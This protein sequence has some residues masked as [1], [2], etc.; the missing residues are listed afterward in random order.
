[1]KRMMGV[2]SVFLVILLVVCVIAVKLSQ[3]SGAGGAIA[4]LGRGDR[5]FQEARQLLLLSA[6]DPSEALLKFAKN[7]RHS[8]LGRVQALSI[9]HELTSHLTVDVKPDDI[10]ALLVDTSADI[11]VNVMRVLQGN[12]TLAGYP[13]IVK[14]LQ[15]STD[16]VLFNQAVETLKA[17]EASL[18]RR[19]RTAMNEND[20]AALNSCL[21]ILDSLPVGKG[22]LY[23]RLAGYFRNKGENDRASRYLRKLGMLKNWWLTGGWENQKMMLFLQPMP[24][25]QI[26]FNPLDSF[27]IPDKGIVHWLRMQRASD[28]GYWE[29][30]NLLP[31]QYYSVAYF[32]TYVHVPTDREALLFCGSD[33]G[34][35]VWLNDSLVLSDKAFRGVHMD[36]DCARVHLRAGVN[37]LL[38]KITQDV[39]GW[40]FVARLADLNGEGMT[41]V[42]GSFADTLE[43]TPAQLLVATIEQ[44]KSW[45]DE[46]SKLDPNDDDLAQGLLTVILDETGKVP[47][48]LA[49]LEALREINSRR[50]IPFGE[51]ELLDLAASLLKRGMSDEITQSVLSALVALGS[52]QPQSL[53]VGLSARATAAPA[54]RYYGERLISLYCIGRLRDIGDLSNKDKQPDVKRAVGE[55]LSVQPT[56]PWLRSVTAGILGLAGDTAKARQWR[57]GPVMPEKWAVRVDAIGPDQL[58]SLDKAVASFGEAF[59]A[60]AASSTDPSSASGA[61]LKV[62]AGDAGM[63]MLELLQRP[64]QP[65]QD[66]GGAGD[67]SPASRALSVLVTQIRSSRADTVVMSMVPAL[68]GVVAVNG[69]TCAAEGRV[70]SDRGRGWNPDDLLASAA[71]P[72]SF[73]MILRPGL[74]TI[75]ALLPPNAVQGGSRLSCCF[76]DLSGTPLTFTENSV[77]E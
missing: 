74:N 21:S 65:R 14:I 17:G 70:R 26:S 11:R 7:G 66:R 40:G 73:R 55:I 1:M 59:F 58:S 61:A 12:A 24:P 9:L 34:I 8:R 25:E 38:A 27:D 76:F 35:R 44:G 42:V 37:R 47:T 23:P 45:R 4:K 53:D 67:R 2:Y 16:T 22:Q 30:G 75:T 5:E 41:D 32:F 20:S 15:A 43:T 13:Q 36:D 48:R 52:R 29:P 39:G 51:S 49:G 64:S 71:S 10:E 69:M 72:V 6:A 3:T 63:P 60:S 54:L 62:G 56:D 31:R 50:G 57:P 77:R 28:A 68:T 18:E 46:L 19:I 33:D